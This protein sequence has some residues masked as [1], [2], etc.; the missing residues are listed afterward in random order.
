MVVIELLMAADLPIHYVVCGFSSDFHLGGTFDLSTCNLVT[1]EG[2][3][4]Q[5]ENLYWHPEFCQ[6]NEIHIVW[7]KS[8]I[9]MHLVRT[10]IGWSTL[11][12]Q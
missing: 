9:L 4:A 5:I 10:C 2:W 11:H 7:L 8:Y 12:A 6:Y 3:A 1:L